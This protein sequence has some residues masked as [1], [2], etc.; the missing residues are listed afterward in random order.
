MEELIQYFETLEAR[1]DALEASQ[2]ALTDKIEEA[3]T[4]LLALSEHMAKIREL[5]EEA[6]KQPAH[7][8]Q[9]RVVA[10]QPIQDYFAMQQQMERQQQQ[11]KPVAEAPKPEPVAQPRQEYVAPQPAPAPAPQPAAAQS[12]ASGSTM[13]GKPV[14][15]IR[16]AISLGDRFLYQRELFNQNAELM[17][18]T[19][20]E[21]DELGSFDEA[22]NYIARFNWD[23]ESYTYQQFIISLHRRFG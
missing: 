23:P 2:S 8:E 19:L 3:E 16:Q 6:R 11:Q 5:L 20:K 15:D 18:L 17:Q 10:Q 4:N 21:L 12:A 22:L 7:V 13:Y 9:P 14:N 1:L